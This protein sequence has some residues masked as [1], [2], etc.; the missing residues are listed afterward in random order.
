MLRLLHLHARHW[1]SS[2]SVSTVRL[3]LPTKILWV[4]CR[5]TMADI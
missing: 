3:L 4:D 5:P 2:W 1:H